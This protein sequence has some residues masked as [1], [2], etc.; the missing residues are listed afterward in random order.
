[1]LPLPSETLGSFL[2][3][4][5]WARGEEPSSLSHRLGLGYLV[6]RQ[7]L[8]RSLPHAMLMIIAR[9]IGVEVSII[10][11]MTYC[12]RLAQADIPVQRSGFQPWLTPVGIYH[13]RRLRFGQLFCPLCLKEDTPRHVHLEWRIASTWLCAKHGVSL[14]DSCPGCGAPFAPYRND[15][16]LFGRCERC[17]LPLYDAR[18]SSCS[19]HQVELQG[20]VN[21]LWS[22]ASDGNPLPLARMYC[23][24]TKAAKYSP[25]FTFSGEPW[26]FWRILQRGQLLENVLT[27]EVMKAR[28]AI[29]RDNAETLY[30]RAAPTK[31][32]QP[33]TCW[34]DLK[35]PQQR[36]KKIMQIALR[37]HPK[38][39]MSSRVS[40]NERQF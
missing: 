12:A 1:M 20:F 27:K 15:S 31:R 37:L 32:V 6:W 28:S 34:V 26:S 21:S 18:P 22:Q 5:A 10:R 2:T 8:D 14:M 9:A 4:W 39:S 29:C 38:R 35:D 3:R 23:E 36:A 25:D 13:L 40:K 19:T 16:L 30:V 33:R 24:L 7:D 17:A 11:D